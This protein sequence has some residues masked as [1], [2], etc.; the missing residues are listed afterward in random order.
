[1]EE[2]KIIKDMKKYKVLKNIAIMYK[3]SPY[4]SNIEKEN[5][6][7]KIWEMI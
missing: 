7:N 5:Q 2:F 3:S 4:L 6:I 1:M